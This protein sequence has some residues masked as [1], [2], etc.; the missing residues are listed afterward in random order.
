MR[1]QN[2]ADDE[3]DAE[4]R[5]DLL[6]ELMT[7]G[8]EYNP[9]KLKRV[10]NLFNLNW[11]LAKARG[12]QER[13]NP[14]IIVKLV[15]LQLRARTLYQALIQGRSAL[16]PMMERHWQAEHDTPK[17]SDKEPTKE[18]D[19][20]RPTAKEIEPHPWIRPYIG[21]DWL[22]DFLL[23]QPPAGMASGVCTRFDG[24]EN[25][26]EHIQ[27]KATVALTEKVRTVKI[28]DSAY[29]IEN[30]ETHIL[31]DLL[32]E[33]LAI[34]ESACNK[35]ATQVRPEYKKYLLA[36][37]QSSGNPWRQR[38]SAGDALG[39]L[40]DPRF[41][42]QRPWENEDHWID[43]TAGE[44]Y[45]GSRE[46]DVDAEKDEYD[47]GKYSMEGFQIAR[48]ARRDHQRDHHCGSTLSRP[49]RAQISS[50]SGFAPETPTAPMMSPPALRMSTPP[51]RGI[52]LPP[53]I[54]L[55]AL[56]K[57]GF[58]PPDT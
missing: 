44:F 7:Q 17:T 25:I 1:A 53:V 28:R 13:L 11:E 6:I 34:I 58:G 56:M 46:G 27:L 39:F 20:L 21:I 48:C 14:D 33:D 22:K 8:S 19:D 45:R 23:W 52:T 9:R 29:V 3:K 36:F 4:S 55:S 30:I 47:G 50:S 38:V 2:L 24:L 41:E 31:Q 57:P 40:G 37:L 54:A 43:I 49:A 5:K 16:L 51:A 35:I 32:H 26:E 42:G 12:I 10:C 18:S 15:M